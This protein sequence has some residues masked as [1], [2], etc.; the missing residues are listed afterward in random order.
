LDSELA[1]D[2]FIKPKN[3]PAVNLFSFEASLGVA[4]GHYMLSIFL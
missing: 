4:E 2:F 3:F 1:N